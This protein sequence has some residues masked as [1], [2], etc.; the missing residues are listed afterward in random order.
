[1]ENHLPILARLSG[2]EATVGAGQQAAQVLPAF[3]AS[4]KPDELI[5]LVK[6]TE[7]LADGLED[8]AAEK[9]NTGGAAPEDVPAASPDDEGADHEPAGEPAGSVDDG[10][11]DGDGHPSSDDP[12]AGQTG[13]EDDPE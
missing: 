5:E 1:M 3:I 9:E 2:K 11:P 8:A 10:A 6:K 7:A 12:T 4:F 13:W